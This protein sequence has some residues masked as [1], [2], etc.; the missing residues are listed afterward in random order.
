MPFLH[1]SK[2][3]RLHNLTLCPKGRALLV[4]TH[5]WEMWPVSVW[6]DR[7]PLKGG[8]VNIELRPSSVR[9]SS[10]RA[11]AS[12]WHRITRQITVPS[13]L[14]INHAIRNLNKRSRRLHHG[15]PDPAWR[16]P[17]HRPTSRP[18]RRL[19][20]PHLVSDDWLCGG[21]GRSEHHLCARHC[22][23]PLQAPIARRWRRHDFLRP[24]WCRWHVPC[25]EA[26]GLAGIGD[27]EP[28]GWW[29]SVCCCWLLVD[30]VITGLERLFEAGL[31]GR[32][33]GGHVA[34]A[35]GSTEFLSL[36]KACLA[37]DQRIVVRTRRK[38]G[39]E[40][41]R[42][43]SSS[44]CAMYCRGFSFKTGNAGHR[45]AF[46][47]VNDPWK[48]SSAGVNTR[49][50]HVSD[51]QALQAILDVWCGHDCVQH[52]VD[53]N[54]AKLCHG[55]NMGFSKR[56][57]G[58]R[59]LPEEASDEQRVVCAC[60]LNRGSVH[61]GRQSETWKKPHC[62]KEATHAKRSY[63]PSPCCSKVHNARE[64]T[65][66]DLSKRQSHVSYSLHFSGKP[67]SLH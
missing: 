49:I 7:S 52:L 19:R 47:T 26:G 41:R 59:L 20:R 43:G 54:V 9:I 57:P 1:A 50:E 48:L 64:A 33:P 45:M 67:P 13:L 35:T 55:V 14:F 44:D 18:S 60:Q 17:R 6:L 42:S 15:D 10:T 27:F 66:F 4:V 8:L 21:D 22:T 61:L 23:P 31:D 16:H 51:L 37:G 36:S 56:L 34:G 38:T 11:A 65:S 32:S 24:Y 3:I 5:F 28:S 25:V 29:W 30:A 40:A 39:R 62:T 12:M 58:T 53:K 46:L 63:E 2:G